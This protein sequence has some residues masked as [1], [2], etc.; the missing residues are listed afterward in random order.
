MTTLRQN[1]EAGIAHLRVRNPDS[2]LLKD[3]ESQLA[4]YN[5]SGVKSAQSL[6]L[7]GSLTQPSSTSNHS[8]AENTTITILDKTP[9]GWVSKTRRLTEADLIGRS[10]YGVGEMRSTLLQPREVPKEIINK[11]K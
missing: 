7:S 9:P 6:Y 5:A 11:E 3:L 10:I 4:G 1:L 2:R 8:T